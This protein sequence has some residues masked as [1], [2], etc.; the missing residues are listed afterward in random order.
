[1]PPKTAEISARADSGSRSEKRRSDA[2]AH[3]ACEE[4]EVGGLVV[5]WVGG[6]GNGVGATN[7]RRDLSEGYVRAQGTKIDG[8]KRGRIE[9]DRVVRGR[10][11]GRTGGRS[12]RGRL[13]VKGKL[14]DGARV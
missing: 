8:A 7:H 12:A 9:P 2:R 1:M 5:W 4:G 6:A 14:V 13:L 3:R 10:T 11:C